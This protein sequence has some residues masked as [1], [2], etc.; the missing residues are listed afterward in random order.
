VVATEFNPAT[1]NT[2]HL[3]RHDDGSGHSWF[4]ARE[5]AISLGGDLVSITDEAENQWVLDNFGRS[6]FNDAYLW[7]GLTDVSVEGDFRWAN[8]EPTGYTSWNTGE[9]NNFGTGEDHAMILNFA[10]G[11]FSWND[12]L[13]TKTRAGD[14]PFSAIVETRPD[15]HGDSAAQATQVFGE[16]E[17]QGEIGGKPSDQ[18]WYKF[19]AKAGNLLSINVAV[20]GPLA[21]LPNTMVTITDP[22]GTEYSVHGPRRIEY[23]ILETGIHYLSIT[24]P[25][26][27]YFLHISGLEGVDDHGD[28]AETSTVLEIDCCV[29]HSVSTRDAAIN[30]RN[31]IDW[32][33]FEV[34]QEETLFLHT[35][36]PALN[37]QMTIY[38]ANSE[39]L[40]RTNS[41]NDPDGFDDWRNYSSA[42][43]TLLW[44]PP[45]PG[46][47]FVSIE[48]SDANVESDFPSEYSLQISDVSGESDDQG[49]SLKNTTPS[50]NWQGL[51]PR[52]DQYFLGNIDHGVD[53]DWF[54]FDAYEGNELSLKL[55]SFAKES[56]VEWHD[57][58]LEIRLYHGSDLLGLA[59]G[60]EMY[61][62]DLDGFVLIGKATSGPSLY[63]K[64]PRDG[65]YFLRVSN[66]AIESALEGSDQRLF[67]N[68]EYSVSLSGIKDPDKPLL[69]LV[70]LSH[71]CSGRTWFGQDCKNPSQQGDFE[72]SDLPLTYVQSN[73]TIRNFETGIVE[74]QLRSDQKLGGTTAMLSTGRGG[75]GFDSFGNFVERIQSIQFRDDGTWVPAEIVEQIDSNKVVVKVPSSA[76]KT[77]V[78]RAWVASWQP[79]TFLSQGRIGHLCVSDVDGVFWRDIETVDSAVLWATVFDLPGASGRV[80]SN[81]IQGV[82]G[83]DVCG[84]GGPGDRQISILPN[85]IFPNVL[86]DL[87]IE[88]DIGEIGGDIPIDK[89]VPPSV[90]NAEFT[91]NYD[92]PIEIRFTLRPD[93]GSANV[94]PEPPLVGNISP[95][96]DYDQ[97][98]FEAGTLEWVFTYEARAMEAFLLKAPKET[99]FTSVSVGLG[100]AVRPDPTC[101][102]AIMAGD[103]DGDSQVGFSDFLL[104]SQNFGKSKLSDP[105]PGDADCDDVVSFADFLILSA[106]F[107]NQL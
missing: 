39:R 96:G 70:A 19:E 72:E 3:I 7:I 5:E 51:D 67:T 35:V 68:V 4:S 95:V 97:Q 23:P 27:E 93:K 46:V 16:T 34:S 11:N 57:P 59:S 45:L 36:S 91:A 58:N 33:R 38:D 13:G 104:L 65:R 89:V 74:F 61:Y 47:Y 92:G 55:N 62:N 84:G 79:F 49:N 53:Q 103:F 73:G 78:A 24:G 8:G 37:H 88:N 71:E 1:G 101:T 98:A 2:Y 17:L 22:A 43:S 106:N 54:H 85:Q 50:Q 107:G 60:F 64:V 12:D 30:E 18:D 14:F 10:N 48:A 90:I 63:W 87:I 31:D 21:S 66:A 28:D 44:D 29:P 32:F 86:P 99:S 82:R 9:P 42:V 81:V 26:E 94:W 25:N 77:V 100:E 80:S 83:N 6:G 56:G 102:D 69:D 105:L 76:D 52:G 40:E 41:E 15:D 20:S 75:E